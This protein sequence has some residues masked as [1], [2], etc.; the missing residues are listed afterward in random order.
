ME[1][2]KIKVSNEAESREAQELF[3]ELGC[4]YKTLP[5][6]TPIYYARYLFVSCRGVMQVGSKNE[7]NHFN[8]HGYKEI[9]L[10]QLRDMVI[11]HRNNP[12]D[13]THTKDFVNYF[14]SSEDKIYWYGKNEWVYSG[15]AKIDGLIQIQKPQPKSDIDSDLI[16]GADALKALAAGKEVQYSHEEIPVLDQW[17]TIRNLEEYSLDYFLKPDTKFKFRLKPRTLKIGDIEITAPETEPLKDGR[18]YI[19]SLINFSFYEQLNWN[20]D[21][22]NYHHLKHGLVH[23]TEQNAIAHTR[24]LILVSGG[25]VE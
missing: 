1:N 22:F 16:S 11:L 9:T 5:K 4:D 19:P 17:A 2:L 6:K 20:C 18:Y 3:F 12:D 21:G 14:V 13:A 7:S 23:L 24:A 15:V 25:S 8:A 10:P